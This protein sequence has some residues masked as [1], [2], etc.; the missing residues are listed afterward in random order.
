MKT[1]FMVL[2]LGVA[3]AASATLAKADVIE[4][5]SDISVNGS[6]FTYNTS[7]YNPSD[8]NSAYLIFA[9]NGSGAGLGNYQVAGTGLGPNPGGTFSLYF[10]APNPVTFFP[11]LGSGP[12]TIPLGNQSL[13]SVPASYGPKGLEVLTTT[14]NN[15]TLNFYLTSE[16]WQDTIGPGG[17]TNLS[18]TG[19]GYFELMSAGPGGVN[20]TD[21]NASF[22]FTPQGTGPDAY[23]VS[24]SSTGTSLGPV[25]EPSS[26][27]LLGTGL[28]GAAVIARRRFASR[29]S[30]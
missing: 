24:F 8:P 25:P 19:F 23:D 14:Q 4:T 10:S 18:I 12:F 28:L 26:L 30:S 3:F 1:G 27:A 2:A 7:S 13:H 22:N 16:A 11:T 6:N 5:G 20:Y 9:P 21:E 17:Y 29:L 15:E